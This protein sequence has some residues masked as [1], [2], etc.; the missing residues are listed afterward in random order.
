MTQKEA[1]MGIELARELKLKLG[2]KVALIGQDG[3]GSVANDLF[4]IV[5]LVESGSVE[6]DRG[7]IWVPIHTLQSFLALDDQVHEIVVL[8]QSTQTSTF[9][10]NYSQD[11]N[12][13]KTKVNTALRD[14]SLLPPDSSFLLETWKE[15]N[16][17]TSQLI[18]SQALGAYFMLIIVFLVS[19][20]GIL[21]T[22]LMAVF[23][24]TRELGVLLAIGVAPHRIFAMVVSEAWMLAI[25]A[26]VVGLMIGGGC[27]FY[28]VEYGFDFSVQND[29]GIKQGLSYGGVRLS[30]MIK[31]YFDWNWVGITLISLFGVTTLTALWPAWKAARVSPLEAMKAHS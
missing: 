12:S 4:T 1:V 24:R 25:L 2:Q 16:P 10:P 27:S 6:M 19:A 8:G 17:S 23:E 29:Q 7:G 3:Y 9:N 22:L 14:S 13:L 15:A 31:G 18:D 20:L 21:N 28:L 30:P 26:S 5:G 11:L